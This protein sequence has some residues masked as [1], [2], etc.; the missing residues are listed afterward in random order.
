MTTKEIEEIKK[1]SIKER[2]KYKEKNPVKHAEYVSAIRS[3]HGKK[4]GLNR[5]KYSVRIA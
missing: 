4:G 1:L 5:C 3:L 2:K